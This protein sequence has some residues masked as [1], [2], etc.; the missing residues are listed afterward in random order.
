MTKTIKVCDKCNKEVE[1]LYKVPRIFIEGLNLTIK[2][3]NKAELCENCMRN[4]IAMIDNFH[5]FG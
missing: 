4:L 2:E 3:G 5:K 1:W